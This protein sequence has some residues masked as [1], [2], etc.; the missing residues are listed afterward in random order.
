MKEITEEQ[1]EKALGH[2][3]KHRAS[4]AEIGGP[5]IFG[6][7]MMNLLLARYMRGERTKKLYDEMMKVK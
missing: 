1:W 4:Y 2:L 6:L 5:G 7:T 3:N